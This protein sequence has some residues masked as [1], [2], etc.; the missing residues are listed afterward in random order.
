MVIDRPQPARRARVR[1]APVIE[2]T[3]LAVVE[4]HVAVIVGLRGGGR[5]PC[6]TG[7]EQSEHGEHL[8]GEPI[9]FDPPPWPL[10]KDAITRCRATSTTGPLA[11][12]KTELSGIPLSF[13]AAAF[14]R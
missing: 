13:S 2:L 4:D 6:K 8:R 14:V 10:A 3:L 11:Q 5:I 7:G 1:A 9:R 12:R